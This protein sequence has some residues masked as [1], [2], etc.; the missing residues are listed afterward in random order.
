MG[1]IFVSYCQILTTPTACKKI[2]R[3]TTGTR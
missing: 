2:T 1:A 3:I